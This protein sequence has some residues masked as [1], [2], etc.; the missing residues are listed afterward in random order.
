MANTPYLLRP[1]IPAAQMPA[2]PVFSP[3]GQQPAM[4]GPKPSLLTQPAPVFERNTPQQLDPTNMLWA[5]TLMDIGAFIANPFGYQMRG[6]GPQM[7]TQAMQYNNELETQRQNDILFNEQL[8]AVRNEN[9]QIQNPY[10]QMPADIQEYELSGGDQVWGSYENFLKTANPAGQL[11][12][13]PV[14]TQ[15]TVDGELI[16]VGA[17]GQVQH[18][19]E[20]VKGYGEKVVDVGGVPYI[21]SSGPGGQGQFSPLGVGDR[22]YRTDITKEEETNKQW[23]A[24]DVAFEQSVSD[25]LP[26]LMNMD[27]ALTDVLTRMKAGGFDNTGPVSGVVSKYFDPDSGELQVIATLNMLSQ[28]KDAKLTP[29]SD[30]DRDLLLSLAADVKQGKAVNMR[31]LEMLQGRTRKAIEKMRSQYEYYQSRGTLRGYTN[32]IRWPGENTGGASGGI[33]VDEDGVREF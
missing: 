24:N 31:K 13:R 11:S 28:V 1:S 16:V 5:G 21:Q 25:A 12:Q 6:L 23:V 22:E 9:A 8:T 29:M 18:T 33:E 30:S 14:G 15:V 27:A 10:A 4:R 7:M 20:Y 19:G 3:L 26:N 2:R 17:D 32:E